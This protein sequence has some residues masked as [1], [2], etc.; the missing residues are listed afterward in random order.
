ME[1]YGSNM[2]QNE[3]HST[4][5]VKLPIPNF[6]KKGFCLVSEIIHPKARIELIRIFHSAFI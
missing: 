1:R 2:D 6:V 5:N 4:F 3:I